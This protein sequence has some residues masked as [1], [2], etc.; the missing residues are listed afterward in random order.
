MKRALASIIVLGVWIL[1]CSYWYVCGVKNMCQ[2]RTVPAGGVP[3]VI[4]PPVVEEKAPE[5]EPIPEPE[6]TPAPE[7]VQPLIVKDIY[8]IFNTTLIKN[9]SDLDSN[10]IAIRDYMGKNPGSMVYLTG[11]TCDLGVEKK[12]YGLGIKR[13]EAV[14]NYMINNGVPDKVVIDSKGNDAPKD[15]DSVDAGRMHNRR[16]ETTVKIPD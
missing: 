15:Q 13:A 9:L 2:P 3:I 5:P 7:P 8:F 12:N 6:P 16:V 10:I 14:K 4:A 11:H 1:F